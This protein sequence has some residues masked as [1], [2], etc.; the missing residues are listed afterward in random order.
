[1]EYLF[2]NPPPEKKITPDWILN[3]PTFAEQK[4]LTFIPL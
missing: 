3:Y 2:Y 4:R 1:M